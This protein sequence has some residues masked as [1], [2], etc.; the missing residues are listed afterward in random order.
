LEVSKVWTRLSLGNINPWF[1]V[2]Y[3]PVSMAVVGTAASVGGKLFSGYS[4]NKAAKTNAALAQQEGEFTARQLERQA[5]DERRA[6]QVAAQEK[7]LDLAR[8]VSQQRAIAAASGAGG[9]GT[10]T[11]AD[12]MSDAIARGEY[13]A[14]TES[15]IGES[16]ARGRLDQASAARAKGANA[17][18]QYK[19]AGKNAFYGSI[20]DA[21]TVGLGGY[22]DVKSMRR[23]RD[24][25][26]WDSYDPTWSDT[27]VRYG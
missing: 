7:R 21:A 16:R 9:V 18:A 1:Q 25:D 14:Q 6:G 26:A 8:L 11:V 27:T 13:L 24:E 23:K 17:A 4:A 15:Y 22:S 2:C 3:D 5:V 20:L 10:P 12:L 19:K